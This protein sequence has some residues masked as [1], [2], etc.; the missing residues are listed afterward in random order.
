MALVSPPP[1]CQGQNKPESEVSHPLPAYPLLSWVVR[2][3]FQK[4]VL[5]RKI[6]KVEK[7]KTEKFSKI[8]KW[9]PR[10]KR[11]LKIPAEIWT[12]SE[13]FSDSYVCHD[14]FMC[15]PWLIH[16]CAITHSY[17]CHDSFICVPCNSIGVWADADLF[18]GDSI[19][20]GMTHIHMRHTYKRDTHTNETHIQMRHTYKRRGCCNCD[21]WNHIVIATYRMT[22]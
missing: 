9:S 22:L 1:F 20:I 4:R 14:S 15:V 11:W 17:V 8:S 7:Q 2:G 13:H 19:T 6:E 12:G 18:S 3:S 5:D 16:M 21:L 10:V